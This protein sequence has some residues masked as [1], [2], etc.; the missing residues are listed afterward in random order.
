M[1][2]SRTLLAALAAAVLVIPAAAV[3]ALSGP[4]SADADG[5]HRHDL[6]TYKREAWFEIKA[7]A[8]LHEHLYCDTGDYALDGMWKIDAH[9]GDDRVVKAF[10]SF[11]D[12]SDVAKWHYELGNPGPGRA[13]VKLFVTCLDDQTGDRDGHHH[14]LTITDAPGSGVPMAFPGATIFGSHLNCAAG[15][16]P[17]APGF[18]FDPGLAPGVLPVSHGAIYGS[19]LTIPV[20]WLWR[21]APATDPGQVAVYLRCIDPTTSSAGS[22]AHTHGIDADLLPGTG[23]QVEIL[24]A[25]ESIDRTISSRAHDEGNVGGFQITNYTITAYL[26]QDARGQ[27]R[28]TR[29]WATGADTARLIIWG[30]DKRTKKNS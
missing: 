5:K 10:R 3:T 1:T 6:D 2:R 12:P 16:I 23:G 28:T 26:G 25:A 14:D 9:D 20:G 18:K 19:Y 30:F 11:A 22:P 13:Q 29:F 24:S 27:V 15:Q 21:F 8:H 4:A 17:V 7:G